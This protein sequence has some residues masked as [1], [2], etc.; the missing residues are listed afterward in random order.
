[1]EGALCPAE[2]EGNGEC[3]ELVKEAVVDV[4]KQAKVEG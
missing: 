2:V 1:M 4:T 3:L